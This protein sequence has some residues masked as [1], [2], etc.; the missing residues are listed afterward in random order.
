MRTKKTIIL[1]LISILTLNFSSCKEDYLDMIPDEDLTLEDVF[2]N[3]LYTERFLSNI[4]ETL[5]DEAELNLFAGASDEMEVAF[6]PHPSHIF[7]SGAWNPTN[8]WPPYWTD[9]YT[10][11][12]KCNIFIENVDKSPTTS[13]EITH[14][15]GEAY[16]LRAFNYFMLMRVYGPVVL[17]DR[18]LTTS[19][20]FISITREPIED[21]VQFV[22][23]DCDRAISMLEPTVIE[24]D[25]GRPTTISAYALKSRVLLYMASPLWNGNPDYNTFVNSR[26]ERLF[27]DYDAT[28]WTTAADASL[29]CITEALNAGYGLYKAKTNPVE[30][31]QEIFTENNNKEI[32]FTKNSGLYGKASHF[33]NCCDPVSLGGFSIFNPTQEMVDAYQMANGTI[34]ITGY[35]VVDPISHEVTPIINPASGYSEDG[36]DANAHPDGW[37]PRNVHKMY[38]GREPRFYASINFCMQTWKGTTIQFWKSGKDGRDHAGSDYCKTGYLQKKLADPQASINPDRRRLRTRIFFRLGEIY[39]NYAEALNEAQG[40]VANVYTYVNEIRSRAGIPDLPAGLSQAEMRER[41]HLERRI[42]L[43]FEHH[44]FFDV[45]RWKIA[46][47]VDDAWIHGMDIYSGTS[48][49]D[50][51]FYKRKGIEKRVFE[52]PKHYLFPIPQDE[53]NK[54]K[55]NIPQNPG[56]SIE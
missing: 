38:V 30:N 37:Y 34:P 16:F 26:G 10:V 47:D 21:C 32:L 1:F 14:W 29:T 20:D 7:G 3:R 55:K 45:R 8:V 54:N 22:L 48:R 28:R 52:A 12:R 41:I 36:I 2:A 6:G 42:E 24:R 39:L 18:S 46:K 11:I 4:Y 49:T 27:P 19:D 51:S 53:I 43:A 17:L 13:E 23:N 5:P 31:F 15:K 50:L 44:R 40:P 9:L 33:D 56:W 35:T 25:L